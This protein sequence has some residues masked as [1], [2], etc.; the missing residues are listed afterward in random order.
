MAWVI[1]VYDSV[2]RLL[3]VAGTDRPGVTGRLRELRREPWWGWVDASKTLLDRV[4]PKTLKARVDQAVQEERPRYYRDLWGQ[5]PFLLWK[6]PPSDHAR[7]LM[8]CNAVARIA[9][10]R[11]RATRS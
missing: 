1:R 4:E 6:P 8:Q 5:T 9:R 11:Q 2:G 3:Y 7:R 10:S